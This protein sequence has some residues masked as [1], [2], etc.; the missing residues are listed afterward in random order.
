MTSLFDFLNAGIA[1]FFRDI[2]NKAHQDR[3]DLRT[4]RVALRIKLAAIAV[5]NALG[6][7]PC[8]RVRSICTEAVPEVTRRSDSS[9]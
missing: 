5:D 8:D 2:L 3:R 6:D 7:R 4:G 9:S 1:L